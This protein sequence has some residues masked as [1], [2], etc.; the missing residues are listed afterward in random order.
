MDKLI[1]FFDTNDLGDYW[2]QIPK[3]HF[4]VEIKKRKHIFAID[5]SITDELMKVAKIKKMSSET[6]INLW[7]KEKLFDLCG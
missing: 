5:E 1:D 6:L 3:A 7:L 2:E 4:D